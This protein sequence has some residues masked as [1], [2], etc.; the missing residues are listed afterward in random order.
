MKMEMFLSVVNYNGYYQVS[1][2][3]R[4]ISK[5][6]TIKNEEGR[7]REIKERFL[8]QK[9]NGNGYL[10]VGLSINGKITRHYVHR[11]VAGAFIDNPEGHPF[12]N[13]KDGNPANN[14]ADNLEWVSH[15]QNVRHGYATG[16]NGNKGGNHTFAAKVVDNELRREF[17]TIKEWAEARKINYNTARNVVNGYS[18]LKEV[19]EE[20]III[21]KKTQRNA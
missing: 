15:R 1:N 7:R 4:V 3:G 6:R 13:H 5:Q 11:L 14:N 10:S 2:K 17:S 21:I 9:D 20:L 19:N 8:K 18:T 16:L 12:V